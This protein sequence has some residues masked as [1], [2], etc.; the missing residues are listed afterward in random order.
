M[1]LERLSGNRLETGLPAPTRGRRGLDT[2]MGVG[3]PC[4][5]AP[6]LSGGDTQTAERQQE[7]CRGS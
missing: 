4:G 3:G 2:A 5:S 6:T 1:G 7:G